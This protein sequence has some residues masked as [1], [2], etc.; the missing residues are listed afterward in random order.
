MK[1]KPII[2]IG[3]KIIV[4]IH[5]LRMG[6]AIEGYN[7]HINKSNYA[8]FFKSLNVW[9]KSA[10]TYNLA[11]KNQNAVNTYL[12]AKIKYDKDSIVYSSI[13][14]FNFFAQTK[15]VKNKYKKLEKV[16]L[17]RKKKFIYQSVA[18]RFFHEY[19]TSKEVELILMQSKLPSLY[20][21]ERAKITEKPIY[22]INFIRE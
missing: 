3:I 8:Q 13:D 7:S 4:A 16:L 14:N 6:M 17:R 9:N 21:T 11:A 12:I 22:Q 10:S 5:F 18:K 20:A 1:K 2:R 15:R 19:P